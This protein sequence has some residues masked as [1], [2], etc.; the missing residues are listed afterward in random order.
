MW[1]VNKLQEFLKEQNSEGTF[2][3]PDNPTLVVLFHKGMSLLSLWVARQVLNDPL[4]QRLKEEFLLW[5]SLFYMTW[6]FPWTFKVIVGLWPKMIC[7]YSRYAC[8][9]SD[10]HSPPGCS[11]GCGLA[12]TVVCVGVRRSLSERRGPSARKGSSWSSALFLI[13]R[14]SA[15]CG[16][17]FIV[18]CWSLFP[19]LPKVCFILVPGYIDLQIFLHQYCMSPGEGLK[20]TVWITEF[21]RILWLQRAKTT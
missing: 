8:D 7:G 14:A 11:E 6:R 21:I 18:L 20:T 5:V 19:L 10:G 16:S 13:L 15:F 17:L 1:W 9:S 3:Q 12:W 2:K 4:S